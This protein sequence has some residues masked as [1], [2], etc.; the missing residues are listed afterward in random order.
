MQHL[1]L[2]RQQHIFR[3]QFRRDPDLGYAWACNAASRGFTRAFIHASLH[4]LGGLVLEGFGQVRRMLEFSYHLYRLHQNPSMGWAYMDVTARTKVTV[5]WHRELANL[6]SNR[7]NVLA[8]SGTPRIVREIVKRFSDP[9]NIGAH[10]NAAYSIWSDGG[11]AVQAGQV[12][13][14]LSPYDL[15]NENR[16]HYLTVTTNHALHL[17]D[18]LVALRPEIDRARWSEEAAKVAA[19]LRPLI[20]QAHR[21]LL[22]ELET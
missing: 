4:Y 14:L 18:A 1:S 11:K 22:H 12:V 8:D 15:A 17:A 19:V 7:A 16:G 9:Q 13:Q 2:P 6:R 5:K 20:V 3:Q 10:A 21:A